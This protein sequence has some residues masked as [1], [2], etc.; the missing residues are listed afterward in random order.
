MKDEKRAGQEAK[1]VGDKR[2]QKQTSGHASD[3]TM[4]ENDFFAFSKIITH[5]T[6]R[7][8]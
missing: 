3:F 5:G 8:Q 1:K 7:D 6:I 2:A 4:E